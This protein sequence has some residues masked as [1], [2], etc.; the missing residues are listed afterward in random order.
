MPAS[1]HQHTF[2]VDT[3]E[4]TVCFVDNGR[5][6]RGSPIDLDGTLFVFLGAKLME[7]H[8]GPAH[9]KDKE[10]SVFEFLSSL[11]P[12]NYLVLQTLL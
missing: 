11:L 8:Q 2:G 7:C 10:T 5:V 9:S 3:V 1:I 6:V 12:R 4:L